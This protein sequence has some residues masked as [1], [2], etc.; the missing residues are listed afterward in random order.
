MHIE[1][2]FDENLV[3]T[4][5]M[6]LRRRKILIGVLGIGTYYWSPIENTDYVF[7]FSLGESDEKFREVRQ[8]K[9]L[10]TYDESFF[11]LLIEYN[12][13]KAREVLPGKFEHMQVKFTKTKTN[14]FLFSFL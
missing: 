12:S 9:N 10:S 14:S 1:R 13:T 7:A 2:L 6:L 3:K 8:P 5:D 11:N 4:N